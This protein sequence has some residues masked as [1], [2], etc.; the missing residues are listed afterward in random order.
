MGILD[1]KPPTRAELTATYA[2]QWKPNTAYA[3][4]Q[5]VVNPSG[6]VVTAKAAFTSGAA[7]DPTKWNLSGVYLNTQNGGN[8]VFKGVTQR[9]NFGDT[10]GAAGSIIN[11]NHYGDGSG[12]VSSPGQAYA[13]DFHNYPGAQSAIVVHQYSSVSRAVQIDNTGT[14]PAFEIHN[15]Q[16]LVLNPGS[17]GTGDFV[18]LRDHG[19]AVFRIDKDLVFRLGGTKVPTFLHT[20]A[21]ALSVQTSSAYNGEA[22]DVTKAGTG[23]GTAL[24]VNN[25][26][27]GAGIQ[28][29]QT[30]AGQALR[31]TANVAANAGTFAALIEGYDYG[32][33]LTTVADGGTTF[34]ITKNGTG[35]GGALSITN[36]GT[37]ASIAVRDASAELFAVTAGGV[38]KWTSAA[39]A[40]T[41]VGATGAAAALPAQPAKYLKVQDSAGAT[42]VIPVYNA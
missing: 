23:A 29:N 25:S 13:G 22:M 2:Q 38:P 26:G 30:G 37:G 19:T 40:Q 8:E 34:T 4:G 32:P 15:T 11:V 31:I 3:A 42:Y 14:Q 28:V 21:K 6:D 41:T 12:N 10:P 39:N 5:P 9:P 36:K 18:L 7:Y 1:P 20:A 16:N 24:K 35:N 17:D 27:T 33:S